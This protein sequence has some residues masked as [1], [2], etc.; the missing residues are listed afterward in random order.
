MFMEMAGEFSNDIGY[1]FHSSA[2]WQCTYS[3]DTDSD[4][5]DWS[6]E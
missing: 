1:Y 3:K 6:N 5:S 2:R 4:S